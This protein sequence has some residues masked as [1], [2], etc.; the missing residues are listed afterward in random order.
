VASAIQQTLEEN[1][2][3][4]DRN[5]QGERGPLKEL[6]GK[7]TMK[8]NIKKEEEYRSNKFVPTAHQDSLYKYINVCFWYALTNYEHDCLYVSVVGGSSSDPRVIPRC[9]EH[10]DWNA[11]PT[12]YPINGKGWSRCLWKYVIF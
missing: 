2:S 8:N 11:L 3:S 1:I 12:S 7:T 4:N 5:L 9:S 6:I 10:A